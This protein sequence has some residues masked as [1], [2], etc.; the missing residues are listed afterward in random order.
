MRCDFVCV[1]ENNLGITA[2]KLKTK[3]LLKVDILEMYGFHLIA[4]V[5]MAPP[6]SL[7]VIIIMVAGWGRLLNVLAVTHIHLTSLSQLCMFLLLPLSIWLYS[8]LTWSV[9]GE[10]Q[11]GG[12]YTDCYSCVR[13]LCVCARFLDY[14]HTCLCVCAM[15]TFN[16]PT[17][18]KQATQESGTRL[19][20]FVCF[21]S[22]CVCVLG[23][24]ESRVERFSSSV[25]GYQYLCHLLLITSP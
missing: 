20:T 19:R 12:D 15:F 21:I 1:C 9:K 2:V 7:T 4:T 22:V 5:A 11:R 24:L 25:T 16:I 3:L 13:C 18:F 23:K 17:M 10:K 14:V 8:Y 6:V